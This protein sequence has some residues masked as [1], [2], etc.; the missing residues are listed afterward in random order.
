MSPT[1]LR[2]RVLR[3]LAEDPEPAPALGIA[4]ETDATEAAVYVA[5]SR[6]RAD[7]L[8]RNVDGDGVTLYAATAAGRAAVGGAQ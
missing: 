8:V 3:Y 6:L 1:S 4:M 7:G 2:A 5:V